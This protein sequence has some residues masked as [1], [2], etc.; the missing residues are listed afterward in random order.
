MVARRETPPGAA[1]YAHNVAQLL[2]LRS[3]MPSLGP[4]KTANCLP[5]IARNTRIAQWNL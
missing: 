2:P 4:V 1:E 3:T 5:R